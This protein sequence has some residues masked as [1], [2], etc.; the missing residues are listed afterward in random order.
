MLTVATSDGGLAWLVNHQ[1]PQFP[2]LPKVLPS[3]PELFFSSVGL[4]R[5]IRTPRS[6]AA[7]ETNKSAESIVR[8]RSF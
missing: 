6:G 1:K 4:A 8:A 7:N 2:R 3:A 5:N